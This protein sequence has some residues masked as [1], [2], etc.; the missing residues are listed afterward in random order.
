M[1][2]TEEK[3]KKHTLGQYFTTNYE[4]ILQNLSIPE[5]ITNIVEPFTGNGDLLNFL[6]PRE[7]YNIECY[8][9]NPKLDFIICRDTIN[10]PPDYSNKFI[11]TNPPYLAR[12]KSKNKESFD[13]YDVNDL[14][15]CF[16]KEIIS[17]TSLGGIVIVPLNFW[18]SIR[19]ADIELRKNFLNIYMVIH[20]NIFEEQ[21]FNDT[22][23]TVCSFQFILKTTCDNPVINMTIFPSN[24][25]LSILLN[26][27]NNY[28]IGGEIYNLETKNIHTVSR[29][30]KKNV[31]SRNT[32]ILVKCID[33]NEN[34][35]IGLS[36]VKDEDIYV[37][38]TPNQSARTYATLVIKPSIDEMRQGRLVEEFNNLLEDYRTKYNSLFLSNYR[39][40]KDIAR[41]RISFDLVYKIVEHILDVF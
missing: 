40:S 5:D 30:T 29:L 16:I 10:S 18:S 23:T 22:P 41:K 9:I 19:K 31:K 7:K 8:D 25:Q 17:N 4:H 26:D 33:D 21:V 32:N 6:T 36:L 20:L 11:L 24:H 1:S 28:T 39:E 14:Y 35:K 38:D 3:T 15:K 34:S 27:T 13:K 12:N 37:D 2:T